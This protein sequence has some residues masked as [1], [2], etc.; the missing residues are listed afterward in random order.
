MK[1]IDFCRWLQGHFDMQ[2]SP[3]LDERQAGII[4]AH[5]DLV[6][7]QHDTQPHPDSRRF[8][9]WLGGALDAAQLTGTQ[10]SIA[11]LVADKLSKVQLDAVAPITRQSGHRNDMLC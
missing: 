10:A 7:A 9:F 3:S 2:D 5:L 11:S 4:R 6:E 8:C 1:S